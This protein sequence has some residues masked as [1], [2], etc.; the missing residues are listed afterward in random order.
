MDIERFSAAQVTTLAGSYRG[1]FI[2][3]FERSLALFNMPDE[4]LTFF[5]ET[6]TLKLSPIRP[7]VAFDCV[8]FIVTDVDT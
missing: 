8:Y 2:V 7:V 3:A 5:H 1:K 4:L 6:E